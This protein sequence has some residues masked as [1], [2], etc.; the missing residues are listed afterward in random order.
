GIRSLV[1]T[2]AARGEYLLLKELRMFGLKHINDSTM[3]GLGRAAPYLEVLDLSYVRQLHNTAVEAFVACRDDEEEDEENGFKI[4]CLNAC[5]AGRSIDE[6]S[7]Y[8]RRVTQLHH[9]SLS[10]CLLLTDAA[11]SNLAYF[12]P[13]LQYLELAGIGSSLEDEG[14][15]RLLNITPLIKRLDLEDASSISD[16]VITTLT[17]APLEEQDPDAANAAPESPLEHLIIS[18]AL[19]VTDDALLALIQNCPCL[20]VLEADN[21]RMGPTVLR[22][23]IRAARSRKLQDVL[24]SRLVSCTRS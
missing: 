6:S 9:L 20:T 11:C 16:V 22:A 21:T 5:E 8:R 18:G 2:A 7:R 4:V 19:D 10:S 24:L 14:L 23:F 15:I 17:P 13:E 3:A 1:N 12:I